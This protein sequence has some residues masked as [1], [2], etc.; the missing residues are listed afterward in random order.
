MYITKKLVEGVMAVKDVTRQG[1]LKA[2]E[3]LK[4]L[5][6]NEFLAKYGY[7][8]AKSY[9]LTYEG[10]NYPSKAIFGVGHGFSK[11]NLK[12]LKF[13]DFNGGEQEVAKPLRKLGFEVSGGVSRNPNWTRDELILAL[14]LY[15]EWAGNPPGKS[16]DEIAALSK[17]L[18]DLGHILG[19]IAGDDYRNANGVYM[20]L[21]NFRRFDEVYKNQGKAGL[22][23]GGKIE[24]QVWEEFANDLP[25][26][27]KVADV[28]TAF[29]Y[30]GDVL[31]LGSIEID[32]DQREASEG[33]L[34]TR[35]HQARERSSAI[36]RKK[37]D[38]VFQN[39]G[40]LACE[41]CSFDFAAVY[42]ERG[43]KFIEC[44]H[45]KPISELLPKQ[46]TRLA[47][48][49]LLCANCHRMIHAKRPWLSLD[50]LR[51]QFP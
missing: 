42:G 7:G 34:I 16:S 19:V 5:G 23:S 45:T 44:H 15:M 30:S 11:E 20:K 36:V 17:K 9:F 13:G 37:K 35:T 40:K 10:V 39:H 38:Q 48:L 46:K 1:V 33:R 22:K 24:A 18:D 29:I 14:Q 50:E 31:P 27:Q 49:A 41:V 47:D 32:E 21:M 25:R 4:K 3:E 6:E 28:I 8:T 43:E 2:I 51:A 26:L 12:P